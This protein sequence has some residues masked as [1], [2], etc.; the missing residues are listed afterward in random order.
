MATLETESEPV[1]KVV[2]KLFPLLKGNVDI[3]EIF[4]QG[5]RGR[6]FDTVHASEIV[7][8]TDIV[9][10]EHVHRLESSMYG[11]TDSDEEPIGQISPI[12]LA[13]F[14]NEDGKI[15]YLVIDG[16]HR[17]ASFSKYN[18]PEVEAIIIYNATME[19]VYDLRILA[20][21]MVKSTSYARKAE[22]MQ[23]SFQETIW[24]QKGLTLAQA[25]AIASQDTQGAK[26]GLTPQEG[27]EIK[28]WA[29]NKARMWKKP[30]T[31]VYQDL[32]I[33]DRVDP[34]LVTKVR[35]GGGGHGEG[36]GI[37][38]AARLKKIG[39][40]LPNNHYL[41][42]LVYESVIQ[43]D[44]DAKRTELYARAL[45]YFSQDEEILTAITERPLD[46]VAIATNI[47]NPERWREIFIV[48]MYHSLET[49]EVKELAFIVNSLQD[50][51]NA[52][53][54]INQVYEDPKKAISSKQPVEITQKSKGNKDRKPPKNNGNKTFGDYFT[55]DH[56]DS[57]SGYVMERTQDSFEQEIAQL[58]EAIRLLSNK[59]GNSK[60]ETNWWKTFPDLSVKERQIYLYIFEEGM[61]IKKVAEELRISVNQIQRLVHSGIARYLLSIQTQ[62][63]DWVD[64]KLHGNDT[65]HDEGNMVMEEEGDVY[66]VD[67]EEEQ[68]PV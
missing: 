61:S 63:E 39:E 43:Y 10:N 4:E 62:L 21:R 14:R 68:T 51:E 11:T 18:E 19:Q 67:S 22:W 53:L 59:N 64:A 36:S 38:T 37:L 49:W 66:I 60:L 27:D 34:K 20:A 15:Y 56:R 48:A 23:R 29:L 32:L 24:Y 7:I 28:L 8:D 13:A 52:E 57:E 41:Q 65:K 1:I 26:L 16:F 12:T 46:I 35:I 33:M 54:K 3:N 17:V 47:P 25:F 9:D 5:V 42:H 31:S 2:K 44:L 55:V 40:V 6:R 30:I 45:L 58:K 50:T